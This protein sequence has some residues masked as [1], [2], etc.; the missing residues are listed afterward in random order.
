MGRQIWHGHQHGGEG[1]FTQG[2]ERCPQRPPHLW[3]PSMGN[4]ERISRPPAATSV[5]LNVPLIGFLFRGIK[6]TLPKNIAYRVQRGKIGCRFRFRVTVQM[7]NKLWNLHV[8][9]TAYGQSKLQ[10]TLQFLIWIQVL[11]CLTPTYFFSV[12]L[13]G[14][15]KGGSSGVRFGL[16]QVP[17]TGGWAVSEPGGQGRWWS[18]TDFDQRKSPEWGSWD[19][20]LKLD[21]DKHFLLCEPRK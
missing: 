19:S 6:L 3:V 12:I 2:P 18:Q 9:P 4:Q 11:L 13:R 14:R 21:V 1:W 17:S 10:M 20:G 7:Q 16:H 8:F 15:W 5:W